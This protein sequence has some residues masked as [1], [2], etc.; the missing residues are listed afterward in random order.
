MAA[1]LRL[2]TSTCCDLDCVRW[3]PSPRY[4]EAPL[5]HITDVIFPERLGLQR[6]YPKSSLDVGAEWSFYPNYGCPCTYHV[7]KRCIIG[8]VHRSSQVGKH[9]HTLPTSIGIKK[10]VFDPR[11]GIPEAH[12]GD[13]PFRTVE[14]SSGFH[15]LGSTMPVVNFRESYKVK[16]DTFIPLQK[17]PKKSGVPYKVKI[18]MQNLEEDKRDVEELNTWKPAQRFFLFQLP[19]NGQ[20]VKM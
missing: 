5:P 20:R 4:S 13:K 18:H 9:L 10:K 1:M 3:L 12:P 7:G 2:N 19:G 17:L 16:A 15:K 8:G 6:S 11:N 14:Y